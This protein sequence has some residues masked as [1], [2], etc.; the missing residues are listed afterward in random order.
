MCQICGANVLPPPKFH[1]PLKDSKLEQICGGPH[2]HSLLYIHI[3]RSIQTPQGA[4]ISR[5][6][7]EGQI[8]CLRVNIYPYHPNSAHIRYYIQL[9]NPHVLYDSTN[10][11][12]CYIH[13]LYLPYSNF[14]SY[15]SKHCS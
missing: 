13:M 10:H 8:I 15:M 7:W 6:K 3:Y 4:N 5:G 2:P 14:S 11:I 1:L 12:R 9:L